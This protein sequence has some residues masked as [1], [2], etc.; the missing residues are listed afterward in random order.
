MENI[1]SHQ[2]LKNGKLNTHWESIL[3]QWE[4]QQLGKQI[5]NS[6]ENVNKR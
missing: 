6:G 2:P 3:P 5:T 4:Q 1:K